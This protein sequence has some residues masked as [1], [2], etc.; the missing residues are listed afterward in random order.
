MA[1]S[2]GAIFELLGLNLFRCSGNIVNPARDLN[3][4]GYDG[5]VVLPNDSSLVLSIKNHGTS[6]HEQ[7]FRRHAKDLDSRI[8]AWLKRNAASGTEFRV[9]CDEYL[10]DLSWR[11]VQ[12]DLLDILD[13]QL[14]GMATHLKTKGP[15]QITFRDLTDE[16][17]PLSAQ[18]ISSVVF[19]CGKAHKNEQRNFLDHIRAGCSN[20]VEHTVQFPESACRVLLVRLSANASIMNCTEWAR[21]YFTEFPNEQVG[22]IILY[23]AAYVRQEQRYVIGHYIRPILGPQ[24]AAW[25]EPVGRSG[26][27]LPNLGLLVGVALPDAARKVLLSDGQQIP[28]YDNYV[29]QRGDIFKYNRFEGQEVQAELSY[30]APGIR[31]HAEIGDETGSAVFEMISSETGE[32][33]LLR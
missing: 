22:V 17:V 11:T 20:L 4:P 10:N 13:A 7:E 33:T 15:W 23:Q 8:Q 26:R 16:Y 19:V 30:P 9:V 5:V 28:L 29:Y 18:H 12:Q 24:F 1:A 31:I 6:W 25:S 3:N 21:D 32:L 2:A 27:T 14:T